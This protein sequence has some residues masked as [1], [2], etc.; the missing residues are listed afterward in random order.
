MK[1]DARNI[2]QDRP[3][4]DPADAVSGA[5]GTYVDPVLGLSSE[6]RLLNDEIAPQTTLATPYTNVRRHGGGAGG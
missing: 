2:G 1:P 5:S 3:I 4:Q 6:E